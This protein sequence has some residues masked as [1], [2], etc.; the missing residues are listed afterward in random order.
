[1]GRYGHE[2]PVDWYDHPVATILA[3]GQAAAQRVATYTRENQ[4]DAN[5]KVKEWNHILSAYS[6]SLDAPT[7]NEMMRAIDQ[8]GKYQSTTV[9]FE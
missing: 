7:G 3:L 4:P 6:F 5:Q 2:Q 1:M 8:Y 9:I